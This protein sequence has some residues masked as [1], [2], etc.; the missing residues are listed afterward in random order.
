MPTRSHRIRILIVAIPLLLAM[1][2]LG[3]RLYD[4]QVVRQKELSQ[5]ASRMQG[6]RV[7]LR[8]TRG[9][10]M[11]CN[12][13][14]LAHSVAVRTVVVDPQSVREENERRVKAK[15]QIQTPELISVLSGFLAMPKLEL[16]GKLSES[17]RYVVLKKKVA[18]E[19]V[20]QLQAVLKEKRLK[21]VIFEE[22]QMRV[23]PNGPLMSHVLG[24]LNGEQR[25]MDGVEFSMQ[26]DLQGQNGWRMI[27]CD[28]RGR[29]VVV[30]RDED[31][32][33]KNGFSVVLTLDQAVQNIV[34]QELEK[35]FQQYRPESAVAMVMRPSTGEI[36]ALSNR[37]T[38]DPNSTSKQIE[39]LKNRAI[40][41]LN[42]PGSTFKIVAIA[43]ALDQRLIS[44][45]DQIWCENGKFL[46]AGRYLNDHEPSGSLNVVEIIAKSSNIGA[47]KIA[48]LLG[49][50]KMHQ[51][52]LRFG[53]GERAFGGEASQQWP[54]EVRGIVHPLKQW[55]KLTITRLAMGHEVAVTPL[56]MM[57]A[58]SAL[59]NGGNLMR[60][61]IV[62]RVVDQG[63][64]VVREFF[65]QV[66]GRVVDSRA[67]REM[68]EALCKAVSTEGT[69]IKAAIPG[70]S[71]AGKT[72]TAQKFVNGQYSHKD[73]VS[74]F[75]G[76][77][78][79]EEP[80]VCVYVMLDNPRGKDYA[81]GAVAAPVFRDIAVRLASYMN[82]KPT[83]QQPA[84][85]RQENRILKVL[86]R[87]VGL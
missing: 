39:N 8:A 50:E 79:S 36:L 51:A 32:P 81:G 73:F 61:M 77:F 5:I 75:V 74:S 15:R 56:Q 78:P 38:Y 66:R 52:M 64:N 44:L 13:N 17:G 43:S 45:N 63:G 60:P 40:S 23:Y 24:Y 26:K 9:M 65:P 80:E 1:G 69:A 87:G 57:N 49:N 29:E 4:L 71:V 46:Y 30:Y 84:Q 3:Y 14:I 47:S 31:F 33:A 12:E 2:G 82:L 58:M 83:F 28:S 37:P 21:G 10:I 18:E 7:E 67:A 11:D 22:D 59:A 16:Q 25:G 48:M 54:G 42:E 76:Y 53:F 70:F 6:R 19:V 41:D 20:H 35:A 34:E 27:T 62:K 85:P 55:S 86:N 72:G 68:T